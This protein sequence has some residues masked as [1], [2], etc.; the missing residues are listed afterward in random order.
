MS[1]YAADSK[2]DRT[3]VGRIDPVAPVLS[4][5]SLIRF[6]HLTHLSLYHRH[7]VVPIDKC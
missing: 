2:I 4:S 5:N 7:P 6:Y 1:V 3:G